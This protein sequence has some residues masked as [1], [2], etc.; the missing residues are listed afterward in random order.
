MRKLFIRCALWGTGGLTAL[1][2]ISTA[3]ALFV[4]PHLMEHRFY[5]LNGQVVVSHKFPKERFITYERHGVHVKVFETR[6][7]LRAIHGT[8]CAIGTSV[9]YGG[10]ERETHW[11]E[12]SWW[13]KIHKSERIASVPRVHSGVLLLDVLV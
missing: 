6:S 5:V 7:G 9:C 2:A 4:F 10:R 13:Y 11:I 8:K 1:L 12:R 3:L